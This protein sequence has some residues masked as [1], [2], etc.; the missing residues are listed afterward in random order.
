M[1]DSSAKTMIPDLE[2]TMEPDTKYSEELLGMEFKPAKG[3]MVDA[4][5]SVVRL[6]L[7]QFIPCNQKFLVTK[8]LIL[9][10]TSL[11]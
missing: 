3:A 4:A 2:I 1:I 6:G 7:V 11:Q 5:K 10:K 9:E 8:E